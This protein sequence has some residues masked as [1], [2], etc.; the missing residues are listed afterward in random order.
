MEVLG[1][2][3]ATVIRRAAKLLE[4]RSRALAGSPDR[5]AIRDI[6]AQITALADTA[7]QVSPADQ[8]LTRILL[9]LRFFALYYLI[10]LGDSAAHAVSA[11]IHATTPA[12]S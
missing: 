12:C 11:M 8:E 1:Q 2:R 9:R 10:E 7:R 5:L 3:L 6:P 4:A